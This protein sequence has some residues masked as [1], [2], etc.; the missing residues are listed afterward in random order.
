MATKK[1]ETTGNGKRQRNAK[2]WKAEAKRLEK[3]LAEACS[4]IAGASSLG[5]VAPES[6]ELQDW[7]EEWKNASAV[8]QEAIKATALRKLSAEQRRALG[9]E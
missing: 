8:R 1:T 9:L 3:L 4:L 2:S 7:W 5:E 6:T